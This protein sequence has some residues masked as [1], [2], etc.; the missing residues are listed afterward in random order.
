MAMLT[1][2]GLEERR[3]EVMVGRVFEDGLLGTR[4][5]LSGRWAY[6]VRLWGGW[7]GVWNQEEPKKAKWFSF[8]STRADCSVI[9]GRML[10][11]AYRRSSLDPNKEYTVAVSAP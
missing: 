6:R 1:S 11:Y 4:G 2:L 8:S 3:G 7:R 9:G 10:T 5:G